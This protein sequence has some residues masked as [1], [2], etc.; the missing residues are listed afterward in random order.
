M[1]MT[2]PDVTPTLSDFIGPACMISWRT[3]SFNPPDHQLLLSQSVRVPEIQ[4]FLCLW[5]LETH[6][7]EA[8]GVSRRSRVLSAKRECWVG[9]LGR[10][11]SLKSTC[12]ALSGR[13][14]PPETHDPYTKTQW[15]GCPHRASDCGTCCRRISDRTSWVVHFTWLSFIHHTWSGRVYDS[16]FFS[17]NEDLTSSYSA[18][19][20]RTN[21]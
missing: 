7:D 9:G 19:L 11:H 8:A 2:K 1:V 13:N 14:R 21:S 17:G 15:P 12:C 4:A 3:A 6:T 5:W 10:A 18:Q 20:K 16:L